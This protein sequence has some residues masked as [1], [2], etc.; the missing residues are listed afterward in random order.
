MKNYDTSIERE[1]ERFGSP[2]NT[3]LLRVV[4]VNMLRSP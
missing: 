1:I 4:T 2:D 3:L